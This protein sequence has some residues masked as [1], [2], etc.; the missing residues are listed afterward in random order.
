[1]FRKFAL[2]LASA[3]AMAGSAA[4]ADLPTYKAAP[5]LNW[6]GFYIGVTGGYGWG[7][8]RWTNLMGI[9][10]GDFPTDGGLLGLTMGRNWQPPGSKFVFGIEADGPLA[11]IA[12]SDVAVCIG[13]CAATIRALATLRG[14]IG[15]A[16][17][18]LLLFATC[19]VAAAKVKYALVGF[20]K[21]RHDEEG[22]TLGAGVEARLNGNWSVKGEYL[23]VDL[24]PRG[25]FLSGLH[26]DFNNNHIVRL[27]LNYRW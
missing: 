8:T 3:L 25:D 24:S 26:A 6:S 21:E 18:N 20:L 14:R 16:E 22:W 23:Y 9:T 10:T 12:G 4:A 7:E 11:D 13:T 1:M 5:G 17:G 19:G 2:G 15:V 27:G